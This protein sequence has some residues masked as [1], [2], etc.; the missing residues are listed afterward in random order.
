[1]VSFAVL[2]DVL[3]ALTRSAHLFETGW[4][5]LCFATLS[6]FITVLFGQVEADMAPYAAARAT[7][8][9]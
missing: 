6:I 5:N 1:M 9:S 7:T 4:W 3:G 8:S 2:C